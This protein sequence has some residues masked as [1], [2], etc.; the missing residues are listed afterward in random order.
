MAR[1]A[2]QK[3]TAAPSAVPAT[4][5][6][7]KA[8]RQLAAAAATSPSHV[9]DPAVA[10]AFA[11]VQKALRSTSGVAAGPGWAHGSIVLKLKS[12]MF[13][14]LLSGELVAKLPKSRVDELVAAG[15]GTR[16]DPQRNGRQLKEW[17]VVP[18]RKPNWSAI[19]REAQ[20]F[21]SSQLA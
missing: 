1:N 17:L 9:A 11:S 12:K 15:V 5:T 18:H 16:F 7:K 3:P 19:A 4:V 14:M 8:N 10:K 21:V 20:G 2:I 6:R 13:V